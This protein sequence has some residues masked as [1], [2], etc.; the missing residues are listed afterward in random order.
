MNEKKKVI[1]DLERHI[2]RFSKLIDIVM[3][4]NDKISD[5]FNCT[6]KDIRELE[7]R[8]QTYNKKHLK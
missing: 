2:A 8:N 4:E 7:Q 5:V 3:E 1:R 6:Q